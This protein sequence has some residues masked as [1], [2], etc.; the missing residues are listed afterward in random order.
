MDLQRALVGDFGFDA[1]ERAVAIPH[2]VVH[3]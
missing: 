2:H 3:A 1:G